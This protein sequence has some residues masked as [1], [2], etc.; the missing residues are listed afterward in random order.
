MQAGADDFIAKPIDT[1]GLMAKIRHWLPG[2]QP[3]PARGT[4]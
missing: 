4:N 1:R 3:D 2:P